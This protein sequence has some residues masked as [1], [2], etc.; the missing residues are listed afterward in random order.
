MRRKPEEAVMLQTVSRLLPELSLF[1][2][3]AVSFEAARVHHAS[4]W[5]DGGLAARR[6]RAVQPGAAHLRTKA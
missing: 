3:T 5:R 1:L 2:M 6:A 4:R